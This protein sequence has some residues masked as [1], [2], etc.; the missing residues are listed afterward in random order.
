MRLASLSDSPDAFSTTYE[1]ANR[2]SLDSWTEQANSTAEGIDRVTALAIDDNEPVGI[3]A[4]YR[5]A[6][7]QGAGE[8]IQFW[9][10]QEHRGSLV[11]GKLLEWIFPWASEHGF[12]RLI[13][14][15]NTENERALRFFRK[16]GFE[17]TDETQP[18]RAGTCLVS[19]LLVKALI[20]EQDPATHS[21]GW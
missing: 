8:L 14:W 20:G 21:E 7:E 2:W 5:D 6:Q 11:A 16:Y 10:D 3:G 13:V 15:V 9:V 12:G 19:C 18:F 1:E 4:L 17:L